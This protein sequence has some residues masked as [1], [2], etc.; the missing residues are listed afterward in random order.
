M[1]Q[2]LLA[3]VAAAAFAIPTL[4]HADEILNFNQTSSARDA[5]LSVNAAHTQTTLTVSSIPISITELFGGAAE[6]ASFSLTATSTG[7]AT[8]LG[9]GNF[10]EHFNGMF[11]ILAGAVNVLSGTFTDLAL[12]VGAALGLNASDP[13]DTITFTSDVIPASEFGSPRA[14]SFELTN[15]SPTVSIIGTTLNSGSGSIGGSMS[16]EPIPEP[17]SIALFGLGLAGI[18]AVRLSKRIL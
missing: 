7:V 11:S 10:T 16:S 6:A 9:G 4:A 5:T 17:F 12:G 14:V 18:G 8:D 13:P 2:L 3:A 15:V 1:K